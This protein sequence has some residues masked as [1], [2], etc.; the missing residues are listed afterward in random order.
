MKV[1]I[2]EAI[3]R[4]KCIY[5]RKLARTDDTCSVKDRRQSWFQAKVRTHEA[6]NCAN[7]ST[8]RVHLPVRPFHC[9]FLFPILFLFS[10]TPLHVGNSMNFPIY[11]DQLP[12][13]N[14]FPCLNEISILYPLLLFSYNDICL[15]D[16]IMRPR[17]WRQRVSPK[18]W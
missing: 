15:R 14:I 9:N 2:N 13:R 6:T 18:R 1:G 4:R 5:M 17:R 11:I 16:V 10:R 7:S 3:P 8:E 12:A